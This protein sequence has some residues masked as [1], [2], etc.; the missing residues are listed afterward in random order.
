M[1]ATEAKVTLA[2]SQRAQAAGQPIL[3]SEPPACHKLAAA[4]WGQQ[5]LSLA[6][7]PAAA[8]VAAIAAAEALGVLAQSS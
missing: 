2:A 8:L 4:Q 5:A 7:T 3:V 1:A 6:V